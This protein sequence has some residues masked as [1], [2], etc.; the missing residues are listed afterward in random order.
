M[1]SQYAAEKVY[2]ASNYMYAISLEKVSHRTRTVIRFI[3][4]LK[5]SEALHDVSKC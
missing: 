2:Y 1:R 5:T 3:T 4:T